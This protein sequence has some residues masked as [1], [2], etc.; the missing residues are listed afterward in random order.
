MGWDKYTGDEGVIISLE[1]F[2]A[3]APFEILMKEFGFT[4]ENVLAKAKTLLGK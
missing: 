4:A 2:G 3:S 1:R